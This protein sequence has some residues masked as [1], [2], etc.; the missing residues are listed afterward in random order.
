MKYFSGCIYWIFLLKLFFIQLKN[1]KNKNTIN[2]LSK[3]K[4]KNIL[5]N[6]YY[7]RLHIL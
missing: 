6:K 3:T 2:W 5:E 4:G 7:A 1:N